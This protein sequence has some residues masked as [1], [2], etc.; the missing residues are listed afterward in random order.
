MWEKKIRHKGNLF[1]LFFVV[2]AHSDEDDDDSDDKF[3]LEI[4]SLRFS[5]ATSKTRDDIFLCTHSLKKVSDVVYL[6]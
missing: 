5:A 3:H 4:N 6:C 1:F 2:N